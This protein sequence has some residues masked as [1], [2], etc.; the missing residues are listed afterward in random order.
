VTRTTTSVIV[1]LMLVF[2]L[3]GGP[4]LACATVIAGGVDHSC[5]KHQKGCQEGPNG[6]P[7]DCV[8]L[9]VDLAKVEPASAGVFQSPLILDGSSIPE[10]QPAQVAAEQL[11]P[12]LVPHSKP[13]LCLL[14][15]VLTI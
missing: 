8:T 11:S 13:D 15:S 5:C 4:C 3:F 6:S 12:H 9:A 14:N 2:V 7:A 1:A 10:L